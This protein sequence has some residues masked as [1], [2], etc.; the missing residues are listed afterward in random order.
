MIIADKPYVSDFMKKSILEL[1]L[2]LL[3][4]EGIEKLNFLEG[5]KIVTQELALQKL[6]FEKEMKIYTNSENSIN[7]M[8]NNLDFTELPENINLFK[9][10]VK[11]RKAIE[12]IYPDF[13]YKEIKIN[14]LKEISIENLK[15]PFII[16]PSIG[17]FSMGVYMISSNEDWEKAIK[18]LEIEIKEVEN[19]YP[20]E[21]L[22]TSKFI[23]EEYIEGEEFAFDAYY[24]SNGEPV[25]LNI[26][27]HIFSSEK[28]VSDR[29]YITSK[30]IINENIENFLDFL[31]K[32]GDITKIKNFPLHVEVRMDEKGKI[33]PIEVNP[34]RFAGWC[35]TDIAY[36]AYGIN[37]YEY[38][39]K[40]K[41]PDWE[42][43]LKIKEN[44][45]YSVVVLDNSTNISSINIK[46]FNY[47]KISLKFEKILEIRKVDY[48]KYPLFG[49]IFTETRKDNYEELE[50]ILKSDLKEFVSLDN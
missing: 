33:I 13:Y 5:T 28:D 19:L 43:I 6:K 23:I 9:D 18:S 2:P 14:E 24:N 31:K 49:F 20:K 17:F 29:V 48:N 34:M 3:K 8:I 44:K 21:V 39:F 32:L 10:K 47:D 15:K 11:F 40:E 7:W 30:E 25:I 1:K 4:S 16:K 26:L 50:W 27:K 42:K 46:S 22:N 37:P 36:Y 35:T 38:Y 45:I 12:S 41:K